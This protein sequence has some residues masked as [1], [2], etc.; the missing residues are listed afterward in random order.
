MRQSA[1]PANGGWWMDDQKTLLLVEDEPLIAV[2]ERR[3]LQNA[4][5]SVVHVDSGDKA[6]RYIRDHE[7]H[8]DLVLMDIDLGAGIDGTEAATQILQL[9]DIPLV[10]LSSHTEKAFTERTE[11]ITS[12]GY[13]VKNSSETVLLASIKMAFKLYEANGALRK[14][15]ERF[16]TIVE[17]APEP[18]FIQTDHRFA[19]LNPAALHLL[20]ARSLQE[21]AGTPVVDRIAPESR[22]LA[23]SRIRALNENKTPVRTPAQLK[24]LRLDGSEIW[25]E[26]IGEPYEY[27]G[28]SGA[29]VFLR[30]RTEQKRHEEKVDWWH[31]LLQ[32]VLHHDPA[33]VAI[34]DRELR[35]MYV[36]DR[37][38]RDHRVTQQDIIGKHHYDVFPDIP[39]KWKVVH[40]RAL[41]GEVLSAEHD[42]FPR[43]DGSVDRTRWECRPW[44][45]SDGSV[46]G[47][48]I[49]TEIL[50]ERRREQ[51]QFR[52]LAENA[53]DLIY[54]IE[55]VPHRYFSYVSPS[56]TIVCGYSPEDHYADPDLGF[57]LVHPEDQEQ[58]RQIAAGGRAFSDPIV[59]R[60]CHKDGRVI[61]TEQNNVPVYDEHGTLVAIEGIARDITERKE[62]EDRYKESE[63]RYRILVDH[64][65]GI[66]YAFSSTRGGLFWARPIE[67]ILG[68]TSEDVQSDPFLW[69]RSIHPDD[70]PKVQKAIANHA[71]GADYSVE[72]RIEARDGRW[73]WLHD[74]FI[75]K[76]HTGAETTVHGFAV[77]ITDRKAAELELANQKQYLE[78][79]LETSVDGFWVIAP[80]RRFAAVNDAYCRMSGYTRQELMLMNVNQIEALET[81]EQTAERIK[82]ILA[83]G[84]AVFET[85]HRRKDGSLF[86]VEVSVSP[87]KRADGVHFVCFCRDITERKHQER[88]RQRLSEVSRAFNAH[89][90]GTIDYGAIAVTMRELL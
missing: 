28:K 53:H 71:A 35:H 15:E 23:L 8:I 37:F 61:W 46:G 90:G 68:Y 29:L 76:S 24:W 80:D 67:A 27:E 72:Y 45:E 14:S 74:R 20:G 59:L 9:R 82:R 6:V 47:I 36:S 55:L 64:L 77:D 22:Y 58:L 25:V 40:R 50:T 84:S 13:I 19:Y 4:G 78:A 26:T 69:N 16:R 21:L 70:R 34:L 83:N 87:L 44:Y 5:Y 52:L 17:R 2:F 54:R 41:A 75:H 48:I 62:L 51:E 89:T 73:V 66:A 30:D 86:D 88:L 65:P 32:Y 1:L 49:Y 79:I 81:P 33:D 12:Y 7:R 63:Q 18:I 11:Q 10:F 56:S 57:K 31:R 38:V 39:E 43:R 85:K 42:V 60:W 3:Q